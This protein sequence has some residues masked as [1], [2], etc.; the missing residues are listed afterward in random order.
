FH[1][2]EPISAEELLRVATIGGARALGIIDKIGTLETGK[3]ADFIL[4]DTSK[5]DH[6]PIYDAVFVA[7]NLLVGRDVDTV[8]VDGNVVMKDR[9]M[10][11]VD[12]DAIKAKLAERLPIISER[13][14]RLVA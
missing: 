10:Q 13:F 4:C 9:E 3:K 12:T 11:T 7:A 8:V 14:E 1:Q 6:Q 2:R 5:M